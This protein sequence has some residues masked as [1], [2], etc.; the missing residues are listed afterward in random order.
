ME[1]TRC[2]K[3]KLT[4]HNCGAQCA[5]RSRLATGRDLDR[6]NLLL[7]GLNFA[8]KLFKAS[9]ELIKGSI[10][11]HKLSLV[12][13]VLHVAHHASNALTDLRTAESLLL[14]G[15][16]PHQFIREGRK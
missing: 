1:R 9:L 12:V 3:R 2:N 5:N 6:V 4:H 15:Q 11:V 14:A 10:R 16:G 8:V 7:A 13:L